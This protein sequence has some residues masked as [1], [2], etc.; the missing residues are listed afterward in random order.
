MG[1]NL[2]IKRNDLVMVMTGKDR[3]KQGKVLRVLPKENRVVVEKVNMVKRHTRPGAAT[4]QGGIVEREHKIHVSNVMVVCH[5]CDR[6]VRV[7][8]RRLEDG[9]WVRACG[10]CGEMLE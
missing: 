10:K 1:A 5:R 6:P 8:K 3:G 4:R 7:A 2:S 9:S